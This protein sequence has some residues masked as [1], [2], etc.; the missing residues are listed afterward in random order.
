[1]QRYIIQTDS[2]ILLFQLIIKKLYHRK[3]LTRAITKPAQKGQ[4]RPVSNRICPSQ[5]LLRKYVEKEDLPALTQSFCAGSCKPLFPSLRTEEC[6][7]DIHDLMIHAIKQNSQVLRLLLVH[8]VNDLNLFLLLESCIEHRNRNAFCL[9][10]DLAGS[11]Y[12]SEPNLIEKVWYQLGLTKNMYFLKGI[13]YK[14]SALQGLLE[15]SHFEEAKAYA[16]YNGVLKAK[17]DVLFYQDK[18]IIMD[19]LEALALS[20]TERCQLLVATLKANYLDGVKYLVYKNPELDFIGLSPTRADKRVDLLSRSL[21]A[22]AIDALGKCFV[23][24]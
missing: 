23:K 14:L 4:L 16:K 21:S 19:A 8:N 3:M 2:L 17:I 13:S 20:H 10:A 7:V 22:P 9:I 1:M 15:G 24:E 11:D 6:C 18:V 5:I 12:R